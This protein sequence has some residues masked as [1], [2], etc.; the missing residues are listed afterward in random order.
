MPTK[1]ARKQR[2][3][4]GPTGLVDRRA[5]D[6]RFAQADCGRPAR[7]RPPSPSKAP[8]AL[9][10]SPGP[11]GVAL[12]PAVRSA[13]RDRS[14]YLPRDVFFG[15]LGFAGAFFTVWASD[16]GRFLPATSDSFPIR[17][18]SSPPYRASFALCRRSA[19]PWPRSTP[20]PSTPTCWRPLGATRTVRA[21]I[22]SALTEG[23]AL[24]TACGYAKRA[25][26]Q[27]FL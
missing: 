10:S 24:A 26:L 6:E 21:L 19:S 11:L 5:M 13:A 25:V 20:G 12:R 2:S 9:S 22:G 8:G 18:L 4:Q 7:L 14:C 1:R 23:I 16:F 15:R 17:V 27:H 3:E